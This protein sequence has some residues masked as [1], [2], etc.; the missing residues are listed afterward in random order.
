MNGNQPENNIQ[1]VL[2]ENG[3][4]NEGS[5]ILESIDQESCDNN[6]PIDKPS[7]RSISQIFYNKK[8]VWQKKK[9]K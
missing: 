3:E 4:D 2:S 7:E 5:L 9:A 8:Q 1:E 6:Q